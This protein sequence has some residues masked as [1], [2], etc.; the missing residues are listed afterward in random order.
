MRPI[1]R[2]SVLQAAALA[3]VVA[4]PRLGG[5]RQITDQVGGAVA[6]AAPG[7]V[8]VPRHGDREPSDTQVRVVDGT[9][10]VFAYAAV[11][12]AF[13]GWRTREPTR[14]YVGLDRDWR[15]RFDPDGVGESEG[16]HRPVHRDTGRDSGWGTIAVPSSWD[17]LDTPGFG[18]YDGSRF[19]EGTAFADGYA[20][21]R[22]EVRVPGS[23]AARYVRIA[24]LAANYRA[25]VWLNGH[26]LG[27]HE[28]GHAP[29]ALPAGNA[30]RPGRTNLL[31]VRVH[32]RASYEDYTQDSPEVTDELAIPWKPVDYWPYA[33][34]TRS[35]WFEAVPRTSLAKLLLS[36]GDGRL[37]ARAVVEN[38][39]VERFTGQVVFDPGPGTGGDEVRVPVTVEAGGVRV[40]RATVAIPDAEPWRDESPVVLRAK[41]SL[42][43]GTG[44]GRKAVDVLSSRYG[45]RTVAVADA[46]LLTNGGPTFLK[47]LNWHEE[48]AGHGR[49]MTRAEYD[50][51]LGQVEAMRANAVRN[52][53]YTRH[54]YAYD[55]ADEHGVWV[56]DDIDTMWMNTAQER[57][58]TE[59]YG[60]SRAMALAM[61]W[62]Q[63]NHPS[64]VCW[65]VHN[66]SEYEGGEAPVY[67]AWIADMKDA[68][69]SVD[70][71]GRPVTWA[72]KSTFDPA[73]D[74]ADVIGF[75]EYFGYFYGRN[76]DLGPAI[77]DVHR[78]YPDKPIIITENGSWSFLGHHG[79][80]T[81]AGTEEWQ[82]ANFRSHWSQ[83]VERKDYVAGYLFWVLKDYKERLAYNEEYNG[84]SV[85]G[86]LGFDSVTPRLVHADIRAAEVGE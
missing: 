55:W 46:K 29:F 26:F 37:D 69:K 49:S 27:A 60:L 17:L 14:G 11:V 12:P 50:R 78:R 32:R 51:E 39:G 25:D 38:H 34:L 5:S 82:A 58:Q 45:M 35:A 83:V 67:R 3:P 23:W 66:E 63:H 62:N 79:P 75:N 30:L 72:S 1:P 56:M 43:A 33:G 28:G 84:I 47:G 40:V 81:E 21:Y 24:F 76:E 7:A 68:I 73:F 8:P 9:G 85:M 77:D 10:V 57:L 6:V 2:R 20:W 13:D 64:V 80:D 15:F 86:T 71:A 70:L 65:C 42:L 48:T 74:L 52:C 31:A 16:W 18:G 36:A 59:T 22:V 4:D 44:R 53:V 41:A 54:P 61:A 19:G